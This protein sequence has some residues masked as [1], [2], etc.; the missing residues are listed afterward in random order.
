MDG[1][2]ANLLAAGSD[3]GETRLLSAW[4][5]L[6]S[7]PTL[8]QLTW[9]PL[10][11]NIIHRN[12]A[13]GL[14]QPASTSPSPN[15]HDVTLLPHLLAIHIRRGDFQRHCLD[16]NTYN[17]SYNGWNSF[18]DYPDVFSPPLSPASDRAES[19][20]KH[21]FPSLD[22][23]VQRVNKVRAEWRAQT[24][25]VLERVYVLTNAGEGFLGELKGRLMSGDGEEEPWKAV[26]T[27]KDLS[28]PAYSRELV[29][30]ADMLIG[31][32]AEVFIGNGVS[33]HP[34]TYLP[35]SSN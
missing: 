23:I 16:R 35:H 22:H 28:V 12:I 5:I 20:E 25:R 8:K 31:E 27:T 2:V 19:Y 24:G 26:V 13:L 7:S 32:N 1:D 30:G 34:T 18:P 15:T 17:S 29:V 9:S 6:S 14:L 3:Y 21:C 4:P 10:V 11:Q 33:P